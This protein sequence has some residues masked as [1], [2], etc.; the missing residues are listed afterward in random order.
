MA[1]SVNDFIFPALPRGGREVQRHR[2]LGRRA[3]VGSR[4]R[5]RVRELCA[6]RGAESRP[7]HQPSA[8]AGRARC[9]AAAAG[10]V[11]AMPVPF[12]S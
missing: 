2:A 6:L 8:S 1:K 12:T 3:V 4:S 11:G 5:S 7:L 10:G 9:A